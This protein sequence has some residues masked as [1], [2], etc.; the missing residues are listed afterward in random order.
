[1]VQLHAAITAAQAKLQDTWVA[2][3]A[4]VKRP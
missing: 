4:Q 3:L 1:M 2:T